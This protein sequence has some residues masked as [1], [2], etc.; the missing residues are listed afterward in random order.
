M[1]SQLDFNFFGLKTMKEH[2][3]SDVDFKDVLMTYKE[4]RNLEQIL[5]S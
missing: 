5:P 2:Y 1:L 3:T 4:G